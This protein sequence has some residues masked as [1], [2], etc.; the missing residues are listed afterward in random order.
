MVQH[1]FCTMIF[2]A[3]FTEALPELYLAGWGVGGGGGGG[4]VAVALIEPDKTSVRWICFVLDSVILIVV[5]CKPSQHS[6]KSLRFSSP[7]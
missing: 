5:T 1:D 7:H 3:R 2:D 6:A 4:G